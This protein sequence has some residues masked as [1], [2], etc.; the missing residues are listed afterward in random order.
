[1]A[2]G[3]KRNYAA[4]TKLER[5]SRPGAYRRGRVR[6]DTDKTTDGHWLYSR[7]TYRPEWCLLEFCEQ[8]YFIKLHRCCNVAR[9]LTLSHCTSSSHL[10]QSLELHVLKLG[11]IFYHFHA[12]LSCG[13]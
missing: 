2:A 6:K 13:L 10:M 11:P 4:K 7:G 3:H 12:P 1:M 8:R 9:I 5:F